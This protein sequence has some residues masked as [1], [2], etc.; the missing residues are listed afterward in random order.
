MIAD[1]IS[2]IWTHEGWL[3]LAV[4]LDLHSRRVISWAVSNR[5]KKD[6]PL[7]QGMIEEEEGRMFV[8]LFLMCAGNHAGN[9]KRPPLIR[10][11]FFVVHAP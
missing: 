6:Q 4:I 3:Y 5:M 7:F 11:A 8:S 2:Y 10:G 9:S 1:D